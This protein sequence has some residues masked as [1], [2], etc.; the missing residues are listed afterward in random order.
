MTME[1]S[2]KSRQVVDNYKRALKFIDECGDITYDKLREAYRI[3]NIEISESELQ[4]RWSQI[5]KGATFE[6]VTERPVISG[7]KW[8]HLWE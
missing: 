6:A 7:K 4:E 2:E 3:A 5:E 1:I 8:W